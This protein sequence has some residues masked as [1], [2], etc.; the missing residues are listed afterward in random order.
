[1][2]F[3]FEYNLGDDD[4]PIMVNV[5][6]VSFGRPAQ[7]S[8]P[9]ER[10][11]EAEPDEIEFNVETMDGKPFATTAKED[12]MLWDMC[13]ERAIELVRNDYDGYD[14]DQ[15]YDYDYDKGY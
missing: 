6:H 2:E 7:I 13:L 8:G 5:T 9:V 4:T 15:D 14:Y 11:Y 10:C 1:M 12:D 3:S